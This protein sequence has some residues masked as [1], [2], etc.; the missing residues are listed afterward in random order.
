MKKCHLLLFLL[1]LLSGLLNSCTGYRK[2]GGQVTYTT[3]DEGRGFHTTV[4]QYADPETF[5]DIGDKYAVD[6][7]HAYHEGVVIN[8]ANPASFS[9]IKKWG[10]SRDSKNIYASRRRIET[11]DVDTFTFLTNDWQVD[12]RCVYWLGELLPLADPVTFSVINVWYGKD[13]EHAYYGRK[14]IDGADPKTFELAPGPCVV[15]ARDRSHCFNS[16]REVTCDS[17]GFAN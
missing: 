4:V 13:Q 5:R 15:C 12:R 10:W 9:I 14:P 8:G 1:A 6:N 3:F 2:N 11:C 17:P 7:A 16:G